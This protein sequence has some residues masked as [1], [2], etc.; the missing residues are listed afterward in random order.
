MNTEPHLI[1]ADAPYEGIHLQKHTDPITEENYKNN[2]ITEEAIARAFERISDSFET[3]HSEAERFQEFC[4]TL[5]SLHLT[6]PKPYKSP[7]RRLKNAA[8]RKRRAAKGK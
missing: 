7:P 1:L 6:K 5:D 8:K 3:K 2:Q 4:L